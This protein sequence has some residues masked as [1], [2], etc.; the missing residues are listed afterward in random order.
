VAIRLSVMCL[1][2][3]GYGMSGLKFQCILKDMERK[4]HALGKD[5]RILQ[6]SLTILGQVHAITGGFGGQRT[7]QVKDVMKGPCGV[8]L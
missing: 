5:A 4:G 1:L 7:K 2:V 6:R 8:D 3:G